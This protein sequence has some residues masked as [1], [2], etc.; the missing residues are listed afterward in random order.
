[1]TAAAKTQV[2]R[3]AR[4]HFYARSL[5]DHLCLHFEERV[6]ATYELVVPP[7]RASTTRLQ[8]LPQLRAGQP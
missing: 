1:M 7:V 3:A 8:L 2:W 6:E 5:L 4:T